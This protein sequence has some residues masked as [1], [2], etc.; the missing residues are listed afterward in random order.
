M[1]GL[2]H[3]L[4]RVCAKHKHRGALQG[5]T[6]GLLRIVG[7]PPGCGHVVHHGVEGLNIGQAK[8]LIADHSV[9]LAEHSKNLSLLH[10]VDAK[11]L[12][13]LI[14]R[15]QLLKVI[16]GGVGEELCNLLQQ[17][18]AIHVNSVGRAATGRDGGNR[19]WRGS[20]RSS[21]RNGLLQER[22]P[23]T[24]FED[25]M[26]IGAPKA[27]GADSRAARKA[28]L[29]PGTSGLNHR[30]KP[31]MQGR[32]PGGR[33]KVGAGGKGLVMQRKGSL[34]ESR[35]AGRALEVADHGLDRANGCFGRRH[36][37]LLNIVREHLQLGP[38][39]NHSGRA[40]GFKEPHRLHGHPTRLVGPLNGGALSTG[41]G[42]GHPLTP[43]VAGGA[44]TP[45]HSIHPVTVP[46][47][48]G[49]AFEDQHS[50]SF[51]HHKTVGPSVK[52]GTV[53]RGEGTNL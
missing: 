23:P 52:G 53:L 36:P 22:P 26:K 10:R 49:Q 21:W 29:F 25:H 34:D 28:G 1:R 5:L 3:R 13:K 31:L 4:P 12:L 19:L 41:I 32:L 8:A 39:P 35:R 14:T 51:P 47:G 44:D 9:T 18:I 43:S 30:Q 15:F 45:N 46:Q 24:L 7:C 48:I 38:V 27:K 16:A 11:V 37:R 6:C 17:L 20:H 2:Q 33:L 50:R 42:S 40:M